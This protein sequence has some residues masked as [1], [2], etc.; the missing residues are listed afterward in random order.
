MNSEASENKVKSATSV[1]DL[2]KLI[3]QGYKVEGPR[4]D[5]SRDLRSLSAFLRKGHEFATEDW[6][7]VNGYQ[8]VEPNT[9]TG[10]RR[11]AYK[12][13][14]GFPD[15]RFRSNYS[16]LRGDKEIPLYLKVEV[17]MEHE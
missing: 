2:E 11:I 5:P 13:I 16:L 12:M 9:F 10:G 1:G 3:D 14:E 7:S 4:Q 17:K 8:F 15:E 6:L